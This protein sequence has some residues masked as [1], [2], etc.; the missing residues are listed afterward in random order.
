MGGGGS[1]RG[2]RHRPRSYWTGA[3]RAEPGAK[4]AVPRRY[5]GAGEGITPRRWR[6]HRAVHLRKLR[7]GG[8]GPPPR[9]VE[10]NNH[11]VGGSDP[12]GETQ[13]GDPPVFLHPRWQDQGHGS[14][15]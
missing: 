12:Q 15:P 3:A 8:V 10:R 4:S 6:P 7:G 1:V 2:R 9:H 14:L 11:K 13:Q 5:L